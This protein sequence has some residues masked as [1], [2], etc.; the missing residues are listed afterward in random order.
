MTPGGWRG[1]RAP[2]HDGFYM[3]VEQH[4]G[5]STNPARGVLPIRLSILRALSPGDVFFQL[6]ILDS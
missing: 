2:D 3:T 1:G 4:Q 6:S 5:E